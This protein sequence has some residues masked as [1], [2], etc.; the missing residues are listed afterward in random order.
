MWLAWLVYAVLVYRAVVAIP[1]ARLR[2]S[3]HTHVFL[4][5]CVFAI[6]L[7]SMRAEA[8]PGLAFHLLG[9]TAFTLVFGWA[10]GL[11]GSAV[12]LLGATLNG[13]GGWASFGLNGLVMGAL[14]VTATYG[15]LRWAQRHLPRNPFVYLFVNAFGAGA[16]G[17]CASVLVGALL[18]WWGGAHDGARIAYEFLPYLP[19][20]ALPEALLN[21]ML[22]SVLIGLRMDWV[23][24]F[25]AD[26]YLGGS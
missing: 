10:L 23:Y 7:W 26:V 20:V 6:V 19:L 24:T 21:G 15:I 4:G 3:E 5:A 1:W 8:A 16:I 9:M 12:V 14:P 18:L 2:Q 13:A 25:D 11:V 22:L 17:M